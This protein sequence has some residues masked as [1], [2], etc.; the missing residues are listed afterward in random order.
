MME[1]LLADWLVLH[2]IPHHRLA[3]KLWL[4]CI[5]LLHVA[6]MINRQANDWGATDMIL[7]NVFSYNL[8]FSIFIL[9]FNRCQEAG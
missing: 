8:Y 4:L 6:I 1:G 9:L 5:V 2:W 7:A 3:F